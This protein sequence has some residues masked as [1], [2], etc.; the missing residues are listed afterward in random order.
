[1][2]N[3]N[4][5]KWN[6]F[7]VRHWETDNNKNKIVNG[8]NDDVDLNDEWIKQAH[9]TGLRLKNEWYIIHKIISSPM[10]R[11]RHT[12]EILKKHIWLESDIE[13]KKWLREMNYWIFK[14]KKLLDIWKEY[15]LWDDFH[16]IWIH[17]FKNSWET[18]EEF[19]SRIGIAFDEI[20][21]DNKSI[22][23]LFVWHAWNFRALKAIKENITDISE[24]CNYPAPSNASIIN[25]SE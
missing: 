20:K 1:M 2:I 25:F 8:W 11:A 6:I 10:L 24:Y 18:I 19:K 9:D 13:I 5:N 4:K 17:V 12:A 14:W 16:K 21:N 23:V 7:Y 3:M 15:N 22:N